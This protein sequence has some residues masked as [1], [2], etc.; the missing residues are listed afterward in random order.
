MFHFIKRS[1]VFI[2]V[3]LSGYFVLYCCVQN[4]ASPWLPHTAG[5]TADGLGLLSHGPMRPASAD[6]PAV[7]VGTHTSVSLSK[8]S[9]DI[10]KE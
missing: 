4:T 6:R 3:V 9:M 5:S 1:L 10:P 7:E 2:K 8:A